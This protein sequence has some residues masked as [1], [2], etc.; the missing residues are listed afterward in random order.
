MKDA[1]LQFILLPVYCE[2]NGYTIK[3]DGHPAPKA[4]EEIARILYNKI[5]NGV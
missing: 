4:N 5:N 3:N 1:G 2:E